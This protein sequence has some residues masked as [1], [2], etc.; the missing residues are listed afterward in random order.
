MEGSRVGATPVE[1]G[2]ALPHLRLPGI[3]QPE[4][5]LVRAVDGIEVEILNEFWGDH[6]PNQLIYAFFFLV[7]PEENPGQHLRFL[8]QIA[9]RA[10]DEGFIDEWRSARDEQELKEILLRNERYLS[11]VLRRG[12]RTEGWIDRKVRD[13]P[14][15]DGCLVA[16]IHRNRQILVPRGDTRLQEGDRLTVIGEVPGIRKL[17]TDLEAEE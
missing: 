9:E 3:E 7:S 14:L 1:A 11:L 2:C 12:T 4:I 17:R 15:P 6:S 5:V 8:A 16:I 13:I 10:D